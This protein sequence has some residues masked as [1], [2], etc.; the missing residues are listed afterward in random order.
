[1][2]PKKDDLK[3]MVQKK[4][5]I[6]LLLALSVFLFFLNMDITD[7]GAPEPTAFWYLN[8]LSFL[9]WP[10]ILISVS[11]IFLA[12][13]VYM[14]GLFVIFPVLYLYTLPSFAHEMIVVHDVYHVIPPALRIMEK[15]SVN[16][17]T[18]QFP[19]S[20]IYYASNLSVLKVNGLAYARFFPTLL[21]LLIVLFIFTAAKKLSLKFAALPP[22]VFLSMNWYMEYHMC[23]QAYGLLLWSAFWL[24]FFLYI[25]KKDL[26]LGVLA[27]ALLLSLLPSHPGIIIIVSFNLLALAFVTGL[28]YRKK[29][30][31]DYLKY[32]VPLII[33]F[34]L[35]F[36]LLFQFVE[37]INQFVMDLWGQV[38]E[39][40]FQGF[41]M[42]GPGTTSSSYALANNIRMLMGVVQSLGGLI[43]FLI[44]YKF[45]SKRALFFGG[46]FFSCYIWLGY[47]FTHNGF[48]IER[49]FLSA[50][51][52]ASLLFIPIFEGLAKTEMLSK[53]P[54]LDRVVKTAIVLIVV[55]SL[56]T[57]PIAKNSVDAIETPSRQAFR[58]GRFTQEKMSHRIFIMDTHE[59]LFRYLE[60]TSNS[61][62][63]F[64]G[65]AS[66]RITTTFSGM[67]FGYPVPSTD[68]TDLPRIL[69]TD[70]FNN[71]FLVRYGNE[72][73][74]K[75]IDTYEN[76]VSNHSSRVYD[77]GGSRL[78]LRTKA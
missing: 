71:Y 43:G 13:N 20:H 47:S 40:G 61:S 76:S 37:P 1:M 62:V 19:L 44:F 7:I 35:V 41:S 26:F 59:G 77:S 28:S 14:K 70:Y 34:F 39:G 21:A 29:E 46:W 75:K 57:I 64:R 52:P 22:L 2:N 67:T 36:F 54:S 18:I 31:W 65:R 25:E 24:L 30:D 10:G 9:F 23:R 32:T 58:A 4:R 78:Y 50:I 42:G 15:G 72:T 8:S 49:A 27:G 16:F 60:A 56:L 33:T 3:R 53:I 74:V 66:G 63:N 17:Q 5:F 68:R 55:S 12:K 45:S 38:M 69:F 48:L 11:G 51:I 6:W 73:V